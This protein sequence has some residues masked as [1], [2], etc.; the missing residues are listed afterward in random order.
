MARTVLRSAGSKFSTRAHTHRPTALFLL[1]ATSPCLS[2]CPAK[3]ES[4]T[5]P[6]APPTGVRIHQKKLLP[7]LL[8]RPVLSLDFSKLFKFLGC[9]CE[10]VRGDRSSWNERA[11]IRH[12]EFASKFSCLLKIFISR[13]TVSVASTTHHTHMKSPRCLDCYQTPRSESAGKGGGGV[14][15]QDPP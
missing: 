7:L 5:D 2:A 15:K 6:F 12:A 4:Q 11:A 8:L 1:C 10:Q 14:E 3:A 9:S 13:A